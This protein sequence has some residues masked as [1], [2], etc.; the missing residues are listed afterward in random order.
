MTSSASTSRRAAFSRATTSLLPSLT[1]ALHTM[2][3]SSLPLGLQRYHLAYMG[4]LSAIVLAGTAYSLLYSTHTYNVMLSNPS[5][6]VAA[7]PKAASTASLTTSS[8]RLDRLVDAAKLPATIFADRRNLLNRLFIKYAWFWTTLAFLAQVL[9]LR[10]AGGHAEDAN[11]KGKGR[12]RG[13]SVG[14]ED[15]GADASA[16]PART[17]M[18]RTKEATVYSAMSVSTLRYIVATLL[19]MS[20]SS[21]FLGPPIMDRVRHYSGAVC[22]PSTS[23]LGGITLPGSIDAQFCYARRPL[24]AQ[25]HP[26]LF[27]T[28]HQIVAAEHGGSLKAA[29][30]GGHD[31]S[32]HTFILVLSTLY[33]LEELTPY[34]PHLLPSSLQLQVQQW[35]PRQYWSPSSPFLHSPHLTQQKATINL[36][37]TL[38]ILS[39]LTAWS[40]SLLFTALFF[41]TPGEKISG[42]V[43]GLLAS[44]LLPKRG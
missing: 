42:L 44:L 1:P 11:S 28:G 3:T 30:R 9:T 5:A 33:L 7:T 35:I 17:G 2:A 12:Q 25:T 15:L 29:W 22:L 24:T 38:S 20:F 40:F 13:E 6:L 23:P 39:L 14:G 26:Q 37:V 31:I 36:A 32:G 4:F 34:L 16:T 10:A 27:Q 41:H 43:V 8:P 18:E 19:W 21:W